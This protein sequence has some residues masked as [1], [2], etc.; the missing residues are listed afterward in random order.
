MR[1]HSGFIDLNGGLERRYQPVLKLRA[2]SIIE[3]LESNR[4]GVYGGSLE[5][6]AFDSSVDTNIAIRT[7]VHSDSQL[8]Y[9]AGGAIATDSDQDAAYQETF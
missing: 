6:V 4:R 7:L 9:R 5:Y 1:L 2:V 3:E 8:R